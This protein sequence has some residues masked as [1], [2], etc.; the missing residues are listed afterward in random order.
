MLLDYKDS[1][2]FTKVSPTGYGNNKTV[3][4]E[5]TVPCTFIQNTGQRHGNFSDAV[6][7]DA[8]VYPD[9]TDDFIVANYLRL[10]GMYVK[11][12]LFGA[13]SDISWFKVESVTINRDHLLTNTIDNI[14]LNLKKTSPVPTVS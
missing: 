4:S 14:E 9:P 5:A 6:E 10:E 7:S 1:V 3:D 13:S 2:V 12:A 8:V 11:A